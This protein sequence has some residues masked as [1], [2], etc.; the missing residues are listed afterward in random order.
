MANAIKKISVQRGYDV[1]RYALNCFGGAGGQHACLVADA[2]GMTEVLIHPFSSLLSAYGM[3]LADIRATRQ[4]AIEENLGAKSL[5]AIKRDGGRLGKDAKAEVAG[6]GVPAAQIK[7][8]VRAHIRYAGTDTPLIVE[9]GTLAKMKAA[10]EKAHKAR[11]GFID[12]SK[13]L[14]VEAVSVEAVGGGAK[15]RERKHKTTR[16]EAP[17]AC[18]HH[19]LLLQRPMARRRG[20]HPRAAFARPQGQRPRH[21]HRAAPDHRAGAR[22]AGRDHREE[23]PCP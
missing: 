6:Q 18:P 21:H 19:A 2:L 4:L 15:F 3:G 8:I 20:L 22:L 13:Q 1:T 9:A 17:L 16:G 7:I 11:F 5:A 10:F 14:V 12:R 23:P